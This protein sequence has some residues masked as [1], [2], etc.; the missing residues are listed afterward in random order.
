M[1][2][3]HSV[4]HIRGFFATSGGINFT[5]AA[6]TSLT[7]ADLP[8]R[9]PCG[10]LPCL[11]PACLSVSLLFCPHPPAPLP[12]GKGGAQSLFCRGLR[13]RHPCT[14]PPAALTDPAYRCTEGAA[15]YN[16]G[17]HRPSGGQRTIEAER[18]GFPQAMP[19]P[20]PV[21]PRGCKG[22][23]PLHKKTL[24]SPFPP[25][26]SALRARVGGL[27]FPFGEGGQKSKLKAGLA[28][29][30]QGKPPATER[31]EEP[32]CTIGAKQKNRCRQQSCC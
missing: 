27:S 11:S 28:G 32:P 16:P 22:R 10:E 31:K 29:D 23:S 5:P 24:V 7:P 14:E 4:Y 20:R 12:G 19:V 13:P 26:K 2:F 17:S 18:T 21:Q 6:F 8:Y 1:G 25:G 15:F 9:N 3:P 30:Q